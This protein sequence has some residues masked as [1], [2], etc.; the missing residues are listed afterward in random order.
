MTLGRK[1]HIA[2]DT[3]GR[4]LMVDLTTADIP[5]GA[6]AQMIL[7]R[8]RKRWPWLKHLFAD[9]GWDRTKLMERSDTARGLRRDSA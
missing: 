8:V 9:S 5:D 6:G 1:R 4:L 7:D 2:V 3:D